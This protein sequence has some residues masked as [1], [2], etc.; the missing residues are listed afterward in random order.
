MW[1]PVTLENAWIETG[2]ERP[3]LDPHR[4]ADWD[5]GQER[6]ESD[7]Q[8][9]GA[10]RECW[11]LLK[12]VDRLG[13][14]Q[15][16]LSTDVCSHTNLHRTRLKDIRLME[17]PLSLVTRDNIDFNV[18]AFCLNRPFHARSMAIAAV[19]V[20]RFFS[21]RCNLSCRMEDI[22]PDSTSSCS[23]MHPEYHWSSGWSVLDTS[24]LFVTFK[25]LTSDS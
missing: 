1:L 11:T 19:Q 9:H 8:K 24:S 14:S 21:T 4:L 12:G 20:A 5:D 16:T 17:Q 10:L 3:G 6:K 2:V 23:S 18:C 15:G 7:G 22:V 13:A 25:Y